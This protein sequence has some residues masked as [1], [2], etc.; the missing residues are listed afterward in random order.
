MTPIDPQLTQLHAALIRLA[1]SWALRRPFDAARAAALRAAAIGLVHR[2]YLRHIPIYRQLAAA[3]RVGPDADLATLK[4]RML[5][6][7]DLFKSYQPRWLDSGD[8]AAMTDWLGQIYH[9]RI[10]L[11]LRAVAG[12]DPWVAG[13][14]AAGVRLVY[15]SGTSGIFSFVPRDEANLARLRLANTCYLLPLLGY[16]RLGAPWQRLAL[17]PATRLLTPAQ[18]ERAARR[19]SPGGFEAVLLDFRDGRTGM[20]AIAQELGPVFRQSHYLYEIALGADDLRRLARGGRDAADQ[21]LLAQLQ[22]ETVGRK[23]A[24]LRRLIAAMRAA[25]AAGRKIFLFGAPFQLKDLC[26]QIQADGDPLA[27]RPGSALLFG[28]GWKSFSGEAIPREA[29]IQLIEASLGLDERRIIEGYSMTEINVM[30][31][32]CRHGRFHIPPIIEPV[33]LDEALEPQSGRELRGIFGFLDPLATAYPGFLIT[34]DLV[35]YQDGPCPCGLHGPAILSIS[36]AA[37][38]EIKGCG[39]VMASVRA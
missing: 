20:Q 5:S 16:D 30:L 36:R 28:G 23:P 3:E 11:D 14:R 6:T 39:G 27:L 4:A 25:S 7:D 21:A 1:Q 22:E 32:R 18:F 12:I 35:H 10:A 38:R 15:S 9:E 31:I 19:F 24:N 34:G 13:L 33:I 26:A 2:H 37:N 17:G 29:L 8:F